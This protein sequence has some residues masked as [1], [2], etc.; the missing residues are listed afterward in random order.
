MT[1]VIN[2]N[3]AHFDLENMVQHCNPATGHYIMQD[4][5]T[6]AWV[7][8]RGDGQPF[9]GIPVVATTKAS[10]PA[11]GYDVASKAEASMMLFRN[12]Q[13]LE[14]L[15][16]EEATLRQILAAKTTEATEVKEKKLRLRHISDLMEMVNIAL[17]RTWLMVRSLAPN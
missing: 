2:Q 8:I 1:S 4:T 13:A 11:V 5:E 6:G 16:Q 7:Q 10:H 12:E 17:E 15:R 3:T 14:K 9:E